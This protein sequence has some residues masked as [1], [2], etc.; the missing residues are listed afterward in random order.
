MKKY[1][2]EDNQLL[3]NKNK[4]DGLFSPD[5]V[6]YDASGVKFTGCMRCGTPVIKRD[7]EIIKCPHCNKEIF[8]EKQTLKELPNLVKVRKFLSNGSYIEII[9]CVNCAGYFEDMTEEE[10]KRLIAQLCYGWAKDMHFA[11]KHERD[12]KAYIDEQ[13]K[14]SFKKKEKESEF[15]AASIETSRE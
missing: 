4:A 5:Y 11:R 1:L 13:Q 3:L 7:S 2:S 15:H 6:K 10:E 9:S 14:L 12:I 8:V